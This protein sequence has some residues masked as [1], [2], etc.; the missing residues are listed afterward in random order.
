[1]EVTLNIMA[2]G[3][4]GKLGQFGRH[5]FGDVDFHFYL[6][7]Y[8]LDIRLSPVGLGFDLCTA[9]NFIIIAYNNIF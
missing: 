2:T 9:H 7:F 5:I 1:M 6:Y 4:I 8:R 3:T